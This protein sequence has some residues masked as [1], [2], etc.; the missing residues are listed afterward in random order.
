VVVTY[1]GVVWVVVVLALSNAD[2]PWVL[3]AI[4]GVLAFVAGALYLLFRVRC[5]RCR[6]P[7][8]QVI[9]SSGGPFSISPRVRFCPLCGVALDMEIDDARRAA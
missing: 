9:G 4:P 5:P 8:G 7:I 6:G 1:V 3:V 2:P